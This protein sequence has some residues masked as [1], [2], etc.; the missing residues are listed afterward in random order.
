MLDFTIVNDKIVLDPNIILFDELRAVYD[1]KDGNKLLQIIYYRHSKDMGNPFK[2]L[3][4]RVKEQNV[5]QRVFRIDSF[6][7]LKLNKKHTDLFNAAEE[8]YIKHNTTPES[9]L[10]TAIETKIDEISTMLNDTVPVIE[11]TMLKSGEV[12]F[13]TNITIITNLFSKIESIMKS[14]TLLENTVRKQEGAGRIKGGGTT[15]FRETGLD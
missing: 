9:R 10:I 8:V 6:K 1:L 15:S 4:E 12:K 2:N 3:D 13:N 14:K 11:E 5:M 7:G